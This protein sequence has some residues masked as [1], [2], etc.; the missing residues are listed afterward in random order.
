MTIPSSPTSFKRSG[1]FMAG[2]TLCLFSVSAFAQG[3]PGAA[4]GPIGHNDTRIHPG[5]SMTSL[6]PAGAPANWP[7]VSGLD[8]MPNGNLVVSTWDGFGNAAGT[9]RPGRVYVFSNVTSGDS[10]QVNFIPLGTSNMNEPLGLTVSGGEIYIIEKDSLVHLVDADKNLVL[11]A[12]QKVAGGWTR[13]LSDNN[14]RDLSFAHG[15]VRL[16]APD[17]RF[18]IGL[19]TRWNEGS[20]AFNNGPTASTRE[21]GCMLGMSLGSSA[22][23]TIACGIRSPDG[24]VLGPEDGIFVTDNHGHYVPASKMV[25][26]KQGRFFNVRKSQPSPFEEAPVTPPVLWLPHGNNLSNISVSPTQPVYLRS[27]VFKGQ[28]IAGDNNFGTLQRYYLEKVGG[29][30]QG[31]V[32]RFSGGL[33]AAAHRIVEGPDSALYIGGMGATGT[34]W[35]GWAWANR[36]HGLQRMKETGAPFFDVVAVRSTGLSTFEIDFTE[37]LTSIAASNFPQAQQWNYTPVLAYG[38]GKGTTQNLTVQSV[39]LSPDKKTVTITLPGM[40]RYNVIHLR[41]S[42]ITA[43]SGRPLMTDRMW[44]TLNGFGPAE[45]VAVRAAPHSRLNVHGVKALPD[46]RIELGLAHE[47]VA[48]RVTIHD[49]RGALLESIDTRRTRGQSENLVSVRVYRPGIYVVRARHG[50]QQVTHK[51][52]VF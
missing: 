8:F 36:Q 11:D 1:A 41:W 48:A 24:V 6:V 31:A 20:G 44:Y 5:F 18:V 35:G 22:I 14:G 12:K 28:M 10:A 26:V 9:T 29:E 2:V 15:L 38:S 16:P 17:N 50:S 51:V 13:Y 30:F 37:P 34:E 23:D 33:R 45:P 19:A 42:G 40:I 49:M 27:G 39:A 52:T 47:G 3:A 32:F 4:G 43:E 21:K 25:H 46:G 7:R